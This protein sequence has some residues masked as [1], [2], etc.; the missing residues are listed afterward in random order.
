[1]LQ[2]SRQSTAELLKN[3]L[4]AITQ[5]YPFI[6]PVEIIHCGHLFDKQALDTALRAQADKGKPPNRHLK[7]TAKKVSP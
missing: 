1:M 5:E 6:D 4:C 2:I 3:Y 7:N